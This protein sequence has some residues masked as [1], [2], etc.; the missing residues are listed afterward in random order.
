MGLIL[1]WAV[2]FVLLLWYAWRPSINVS[3]ANGR[4]NLA[5]QFI[6]NLPLSNTLLPVILPT[7]YLWVVDTLALQRGTWVIESDTKLGWYLWDGLEVE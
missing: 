3:T 4:R 1:V 6:I 5:Y 7:A 2:P